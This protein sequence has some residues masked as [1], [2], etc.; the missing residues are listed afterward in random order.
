MDLMND[1]LCAS[2]EFSLKGST[3]PVYAIL[4]IPISDG[5]DYFCD[6]KVHGLDKEIN[7]RAFGI[8]AFQAL[9][10]G[11]NALGA[12][13]YFSEAYRNGLLSWGENRKDGNLGIP[14]ASSIADLVPS[15]D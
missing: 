9:I 3:I 7:G 5:Q 2:R 13:L 14:V 1:S 8:D 11:L 10:H 4:T 15:V 12:A 6:Y